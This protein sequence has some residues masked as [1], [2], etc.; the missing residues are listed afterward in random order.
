MAKP[1]NISYKP[2]DEIFLRNLG[3]LG[4]LSG[5]ELYSKVC[6][7][8]G[9][10]QPNSSRDAIVDVFF[11][12]NIARKNKK[13]LT[14]K[15]I[16]TLVDANR[17]QF[18]LGKDDSSGSNIRRILKFLMNYGFI[19]RKSSKYRFKDF[20]D[21]DLIFQDIINSRV[22]VIIQKNLDYLKKL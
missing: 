10:V 5:R 6:L 16:N 2:I 22:K 14:S 15:E 8:L 18:L 19:E 11:V 21:L 9:F 1:I 3:Y 12:L 20:K 7:S 17:S 13:W 4:D